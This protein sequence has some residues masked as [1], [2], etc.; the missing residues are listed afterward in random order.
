MRL[1]RRAWYR[2]PLWWMVILIGWPMVAVACLFIL[3]L[4][5]RTPPVTYERLQA[6]A[7]D[8]ATRILTLQWVVHRR[9]YCPGVVLRTV[10]GQVGGTIQLQTVIIDPEVDPQ[11]VRDARIG[12]T[13]VGRA[14]QIEIPAT[15]GGTIRLTTIP[16]NWCWPF[17]QFVPIETATPPIH[18]SSEPLIFAKCVSCPANLASILPAT[19]PACMPR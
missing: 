1:E 9:R 15:L 3:S 17:Q 6:G 10:E 14:S 16:R 19:S 5:D 7:Y 4:A 11:N 18:F 2:Q 13:Y 8:P 12:S